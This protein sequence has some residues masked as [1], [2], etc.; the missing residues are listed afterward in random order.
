MYLGF[1]INNKEMKRVL[2]NAELMRSMPDTKSVKEVR[3]FIGII[4]NFSKFISGFSE[5]AMTLIILSKTCQV[6]MDRGLPENF[7]HTER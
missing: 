4:R 3:R 7:L 6:S 1:V 5:I 2:V